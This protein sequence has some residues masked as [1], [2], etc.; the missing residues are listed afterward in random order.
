VSTSDERLWRIEHEVKLLEERQNISRFDNL[1]FLSYPLVILGLSLLINVIREYEMILQT[2]I[3]G[4]PGYLIFEMVF[5]TGIVFILVVVFGFGKFLYAY[6]TDDL[7]NR[8]DACAIFLFFPIVPIVSAIFL[9]IVPVLVTLASISNL[10][11]LSLLMPLACGISLFCIWGGIILGLECRL[12]S[13]F[14]RNAPFASAAAKGGRIKG[15]ARGDSLP[16]IA[17][18]WRDAIRQTENN[19]LFVGTLAWFA[20][21]LFYAIMIGG[22]IR[23]GGLQGIAGFHCGIL[24]ALVIV[25]AAIL[26]RADRIRQQIASLQ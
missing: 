9:S 19:F 24:I 23:I 2:S 13:W 7:S 26:L 3:M 11:I 20:F 8:V 25:T 4:V 6:A 22:A 14:H 17:P 15:M 5:Y 16:F 10:L 21:L 1:M 18:E 12:I